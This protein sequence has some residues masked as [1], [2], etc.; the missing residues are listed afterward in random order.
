MRGSKSRYGSHQVD[1]ENPYWMSFS[2][3]MAG[4]LVIFILAAV[5]LILELTEKRAKWDQAI[6]DIAK[7]EQVRKDILRE[8]EIEL[9]SKNI[10]VVVSDN[11]TVLRIPEQALTFKQGSFDIPNDDYHR[12]IVVE[13]GEVLYKAISKDRRWEYLDTVFIEGH[14]DKIPYRNSSFKGNWGLSTFRAISLWDFWNANMDKNYIL[15]NIKNHSGDRLFSVSGYA[16]TR[17]VPCS[18]TGQD[19]DDV[20]LCPSGILSVNESLAKNRRIDIRVTVKKPSMETMQGTREA[21]D[22]AKAQ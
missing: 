17:P 15:E 7:A 16:E 1:E 22:N 3:I 19:I 6:E 2:D 14:T 20:D 13:I 10:P 21:I 5:V 11:D 4:L 8:V 12:S 18:N 9:N